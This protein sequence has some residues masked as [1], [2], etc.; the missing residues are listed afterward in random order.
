MFD[1]IVV[2]TDGSDSVQRAVSVAVDVAARFDAEV[3][4]VYVVDAGEVESSPDTVRE[5]LRDA[6]DDQGSDALDRVADAAHDR[7]GD[8]DV[9]IEVREG[10]PASE[11]DAYARSADADLVAMGTRGR[12][13]E[14]RFLIGSVAERVVRTCPVPVLTVRQ[15]TDEDPRRT[16]I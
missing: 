16:T 13:G 8:L 9:T 15:L 1:T 12:H 4:A 5:D 6:L 7:D 14:N 2:A 10:R 11:I 3:H